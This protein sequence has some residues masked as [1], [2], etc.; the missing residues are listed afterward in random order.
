M[1]E[2]AHTERNDSVAGSHDV[3]SSEH[4]SVAFQQLPSSNATA[5]NI[6]AGHNAH[7]KIGN[8]FNLIRSKTSDLKRNQIFDWLSP[9]SFKRTLER[10][11]DD[12]ALLDS[13]DYLKNGLY[14]GKWLLESETFDKW[15]SRDLRK[16]W[17]LGMR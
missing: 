6:N 13:S 12:A 15:R 4:G 11:R 14:S 5:G 17:Y 10:I 2:E 8:T 3:S 16:L 9:L 1:P 7:I